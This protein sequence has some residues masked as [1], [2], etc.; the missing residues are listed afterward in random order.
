MSIAEKFET[1][2]DEVYDAGKKAEY[3]AFW[4]NF[5][6]NGERNDYRYAFAMWA[7]DIFYPKHDITCQAETTYMFLQ[8]T[9]K[10][11]KQRL[12]DLGVEFSM[13]GVTRCTSMFN[14]AKITHLPTID[15]SSCGTYTASVLAYCNNLI[16]V[17]L[18]VSENNTFTTAFVNDFA[19]E[20][21][22]IEGTIGQT[23]FNV[24]WSTKL[25][26]ASITSIVNALSSTTSGLTVTISKTAKEAAF[27][28]DEWS[29]L[30]KTK[31]NWTI[32]L[33]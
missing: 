32:S 21:L 4:D 25:S 13:E 9:I 20:N 7:D 26:K 12:I 2:A 19:L 29:A 1:I 5:Q 16:E 18:I 24:Q 22:T 8:S 15:I 23:G 28:A 11:I 14:S 17:K 33:V 10:N 3:D 31:S 27:T 30:I 6:N